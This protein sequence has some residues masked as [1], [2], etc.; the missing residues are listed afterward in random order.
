MKQYH[1]AEFGQA[2]NKY[3]HH[4]TGVTSETGQRRSRFYYNEQGKLIRNELLGT[5]NEVTRIAYDS[6]TVSTV[7]T[8]E[9]VVQT[10]TIAPGLLRRVTSVST[11]G[12]GTS[13]HG[14]DTES[15]L[16][17]SVTDRNNVT[18]RYEYDP[19]HRDV[20]ATIEAD[21]TLQ[22]RRIEYIRDPQTRLVTEQRIRDRSGALVA[23]A[24]AAYNDRQQVTVRH[25]QRPGRKLV[26][27]IDDDLLRSR[28]CERRGQHLSRFLVWLS[29]S[30]ARCPTRA[31]R[32][33]SPVS[34]TG[35]ADAPG[36]AEAPTTCAWRKGDLWKTINAKGHV[37]EILAYD[38]SGRIRSVKDANWVVMDIEYNH[39]GWVTARKV[40]GG[41]DGSETD[42]RITRMEY[43]A[44]GTVKK[45]IQPDGSHLTYGYD[46]SGRLISITDS[47][48]NSVTYTLNAVGERVREDNR[49]SSG[50]LARTL[51]RVYNNLG[52][53]D[54][55]VNAGS[56]VTAF[57]YDNEGRSTKAI[58]ALS[59]ES[60]RE[61][62]GL[63]RLV[64]E[65]RNATS[66]ADSAETRYAFDPLDRITSIVDPSGKTTAYEYNAYGE[67]VGL[68]SPDTGSTQSTYDACRSPADQNRRAWHHGDLW[69]RCA[70]SHDVGDLSG[71]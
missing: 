67:L 63:G 20:I 7:T 4:L 57:Q 54:S 70:R 17:N 26:A 68:S 9:G 3:I 60:V 64:R 34:S 11:P 61:Y 8:A 43:F 49:D 36:C 33:T 32:M 56:H 2:M 48:G 21:T 10:Y 18:T 58:D 1:Y 40:R 35:A 6:D 66:A 30:M 23:K 38:G 65:L 27:C 16:L 71:Q 69:L 39:R 12:M 53:L 47:L 31:S 62:D 29:R 42:D 51:A 24:G 45:V 55:I 59:R 44:D 50:N 14:Y 52:Q 28:R 37:T 5:P 41:N 22:Q 25:A 46:P 13:A 15:G 19:T